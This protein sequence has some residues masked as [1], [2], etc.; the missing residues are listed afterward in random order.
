VKTIRYYE[1]RGVL[2]APGRTAANDR[3]HGKAPLRPSFIRRCRKLGSPLE[4]V[5]ALLRLSDRPGGP[6]VEAYQSADKHP[7]A[8]DR[9][10]A[11]RRSLGSELTDLVGKFRDRTA[12]PACRII[13]ALAPHG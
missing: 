11:D 13:E 2:A 3:T 4:R 8:I 12:P 6:W 9:K 7:G 5:G 1:R 10:I